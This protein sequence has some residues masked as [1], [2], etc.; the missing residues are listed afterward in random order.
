MSTNPASTE[1]SLLRDFFHRVSLKIKF[2]VVILA[3]IVPLAGAGLYGARSYEN[4]VRTINLAHETQDK[5]HDIARE[6]QYYFEQQIQEWK[7]ILIRGKNASEYHEYLS[8]FYGNERAV[9]AA[10]NKISEGEK[11]GSLVAQTVSLLKTAHREAGRKYRRAIRIYNGTDVDSLRS[12]DELVKGAHEETSTL[13]VELIDAIT[14]DKN[15]KL[16]TARGTID[17]ARTAALTVLVAVTLITAAL[18][19]LL[20]ARGI[21]R[22]IDRAVSVARSIASGN[23]DRPVETSGSAEMG[24]LLRALDS[25]RESLQQAVGRSEMILNA[26]GDGI[27]GV[28]LSGCCTFINPAALEMLGW[29]AADIIGKQQHTLMHHTKADGSPYPRRESPIY[30]AFTDKQEH[31]VTGEVFWRKDGTSFPVEYTSTPIFQDGETIG[32]VVTFRDVTERIRAEEGLRNMQ[33]TEALGSLAGGIAH[34]LNNLLLPIVA[35]SGLAAQ[36]APQGSE[37]RERLS[38]ITL[39]GERARELVS[40]I[41]T[42]SR[43]EPANIRPVEIRSV[44]EDALKLLHPSLPST[45]RVE[46]EL[47]DN[48]GMVEADPVQIESVMMN[49]VNNSI[50][51]ISSPATGVVRITL[52]SSNIDAG[53]PVVQKGIT[54]GRYAKIS[55]SDNGDGMSKEI[56]NRIFDPFFTTKG[57]GKGTGLGLSM[58]Q[59][60]VSRH[61][62]AIDVVSKL[63]EGTTFTIYL[64]GIE[65]QAPPDM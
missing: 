50:A 51:A 57:V 23:L 58:A 64:P 46:T 62:G 22:P 10:I 52:E 13:I 25:M 63:G 47:S 3:V 27:Y 11:E 44:V 6:T 31:T 20:L 43:R 40:R 4:A 18:L 48:A 49:M 30:A 32:A 16:T 45:I 24:T 29:K 53:E 12:A 28:D 9:S 8:N 54:P 19:V 37:N 42:F 55:I 38:K 15:R 2:S 65:G 36:K 14:W 21:L 5:Q 33:K 59:G 34:S 41:L 7:N 60:I 39:A 17:E 35:L 26:A 61:G 56:L 1:P